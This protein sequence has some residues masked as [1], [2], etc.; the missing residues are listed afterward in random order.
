MRSDV[1]L[2]QPIDDETIRCEELENRSVLDSLQRPDPGIEL[3]LRQFCLEVAHA[4]IP[5]CRVR[6]QGVSPVNAQP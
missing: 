2:I 4:T 1:M 3:L 5:Y 6:L